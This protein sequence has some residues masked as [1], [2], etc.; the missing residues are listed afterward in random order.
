M[1]TPDPAWITEAAR[2]LAAEI[3]PGAEI[4]ILTAGTVTPDGL[5]TRCTR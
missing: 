3:E 1:T 4:D 2:A 5:Y